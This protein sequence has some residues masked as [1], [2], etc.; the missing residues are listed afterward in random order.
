MIK[1]NRTQSLCAAVA[2]AF[3]IIRSLRPCISCPDAVAMLKKRRTGPSL[4]EKGALLLEAAKI[5]FSSINARGTA[6]N[7]VIKLELQPNPALPP[8]DPAV[9][10]YPMRYSMIVGWEQ[11]P[12]TASAVTCFLALFLF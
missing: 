9:R 1:L 11:V 6:K 8:G 5:G 2:A 10:Y 7:M 12:H 3:V 4:E